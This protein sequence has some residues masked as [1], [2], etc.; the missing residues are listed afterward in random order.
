MAMGQSS[1]LISE[2]RLSFIGIDR[3]V[4]Y[5]VE[6][7]LVYSKYSVKLLENK[8]NKNIILLVIGVCINFFL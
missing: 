8:D 3:V 1:L 2:I 6:I 5:C 4:W 7:P